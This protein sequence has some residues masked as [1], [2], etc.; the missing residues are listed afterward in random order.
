M[1]KFRIIIAFSLFCLSYESWTQL[2][3]VP[4]KDIQ[5]YHLYPGQNE[6]K[7]NLPSP[8][9]SETGVE[10]LIAVTMN[11]QYALIP[12]TIRNGRKI[13]PNQ[14]YSDSLDFPSFTL[15]GLHNENQLDQIETITG[16][17]ITKITDLALPGGLSS[18]GFISNGENLIDLLKKDNKLVCSLNLTHLT[19]AKPIF[20][21]INM[22]EEDLKLKRW[23]IAKQEWGHILY[24]C[25]NQNRIWIQAFNRKEAQLSV[26][27]DGIKAFYNI[28]LWREFSDEE[29]IFLKQNYSSLN[30]FQFNELKAKL[31]YINISEMQAQYIM[32][33]GFY[34]GHTIWRADPLAISFIFGLKSLVE[35][36]HA[37]GNDLFK[38]VSS[39]DCP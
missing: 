6:E 27:D 22:M 35:L 4:M 16:R 32:R 11:R 38:V 31:S 39:K 8:L 25:Y 33:Y 23:N 5:V 19:L 15:N 9:V 1:L 3:F 14:L 17:S 20:H 18:D 37:S 24:F 7:P 12:V 26:F 34:G 2:T 36:H 29:L 21:V 13:I 28:K 10:Y 30:T